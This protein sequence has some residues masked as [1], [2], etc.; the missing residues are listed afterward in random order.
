MGVD[1]WLMMCKKVKHLT[2]QFADWQPSDSDHDD[3]GMFDIH[4]IAMHGLISSYDMVLFQFEAVGHCTH[5][6]Y[7]HSAVVSVFATVG[8]YVAEITSKDFMLRQHTFTSLCGC[9]MR[10]PGLLQ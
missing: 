10:L 4:P 3:S 6:G 5:S 2:D 9:R 8:Y 7:F 1:E